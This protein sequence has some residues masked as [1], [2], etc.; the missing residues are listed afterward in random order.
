MVNFYFEIKK[1]SVKKHGGK[2]FVVDGP[3]ADKL[4]ATSKLLKDS[5]R[6]WCEKEGHVWYMGSNK[7]VDLKEFMWVKLQAEVAYG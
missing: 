6:I 4:R 3:V 7:E 2:Y 5:E 1:P